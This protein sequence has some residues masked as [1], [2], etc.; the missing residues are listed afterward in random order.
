MTQHGHDIA[1]VIGAAVNVD[2]VKIHMPKKELQMQLCVKS[3]SQNDRAKCS[4]Q[5][6]GVAVCLHATFHAVPWHR[7]QLLVT[8][9]WLFWSFVTHYG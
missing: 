2:A 4:L 1:N 3:D 8:P 5:H 7:K 6:L 9:S